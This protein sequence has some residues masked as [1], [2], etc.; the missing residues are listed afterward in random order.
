M[1][2]P[3]VSSVEAVVLV[4]AVCTARNCTPEAEISIGSKSLADE[5]AKDSPNAGYLAGCIGFL[6]ECEGCHAEYVGYTW[7]TS[8]NA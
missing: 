6:A 1:G 4:V 3:Q 7:A 5:K 8:S 2:V